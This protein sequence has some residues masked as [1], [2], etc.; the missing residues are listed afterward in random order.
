MKTINFIIPQTN[1]HKYTGG[2]WC[3]FEYA[4]GLWEKGYN[5]NLIPLLPC[6][7]QKWF[8]KQCGNFLNTSF[9]N[10]VKLFFS[11]FL[12]LCLS[13]FLFPITKKKQLIKDSAKNFQI[14]ISLLIPNSLPY[15]MKRA[16]SI[17]YLKNFIPDADATIAT[18]FETALPTRLFGKGVLF[19]FL[20][21]FEPFFKNEFSNPD[22][23]EIEASLSYELNLNLIC[24]SSWLRSKINETKI[25]ISTSLCPNAIDHS[26]FYGSPKTAIKN[27]EIKVISYGGR[28]ALWKGFKEMAEA[29]KIAREKLPNLKIRW[30]VY[31]DAILPS[32]NKIASYENLGFLTPNQ[33]AESY[34]NADILLSASWYESFPLFPI[35]AMACGLPVITTKF[36]TEEYAINDITAKIVEPRNSQNIAFGLIYLIENIDYRNKIA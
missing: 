1:K 12:Y 21:H 20:Q 24:N 31:G 10:R 13:L 36:G 23:A 4:H 25:D 34:R 33:L 9:L 6:P 29:V 17:P 3:I 11:S 19:N 27:K 30:Q 26:I 8:K 22:L 32:N 18:S 35:E 2:L 5:I 28:N 7:E 15:E 14:A 16:A